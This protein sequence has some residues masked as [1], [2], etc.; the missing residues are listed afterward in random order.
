MRLPKP[1]ASARVTRILP[2]GGNRSAFRTCRDNRERWARHRG[3]TY[4]EPREQ[5]A[6]QKISPTLAS[7]LKLHRP[8]PPLTPCGCGR[9]V[10]RLAIRFC[11]SF[12]SFFSAALPAQVLRSA[13]QRGDNHPSITVPS[14]IET[15]SV[16]I[17]LEHPLCLR[18]ML[19][20]DGP[21]ILVSSPRTPEF[22]S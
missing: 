20:F 16:M 6:D 21:M 4:R 5:K 22:R 14:F 17:P 1:R 8:S 9:W 19:K 10:W 13:S 2:E 15:G 11:V 7:R 3:S 12:W 18:R